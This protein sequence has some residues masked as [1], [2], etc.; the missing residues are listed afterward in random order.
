MNPNSILNRV[1]AGRCDIF[2]GAQLHLVARHRANDAS[3]PT[4]AARGGPWRGRI[5]PVLAALA[6][7][8]FSI[9]A[10][11]ADVVVSSKAD[12]EGN[13]LGNIIVEVLA[14]HGVP[15]QSR[16]QLGSTS[17]V[18]SAIATG[19]IDIYPEYTGDGAFLFNSTDDAIWKD[20]AQSY[21][22]VKRLD[23]DANKL[24][25]LGAAPA[26]NTWGI[27]LR[28]DVADANH[29]ATFSDFATWVGAG[30]NIKLAASAVF[31]NSPPARPAFEKAYGF[32]LRSD[33]LVSLTAGDTAE[34]IAAAAQQTSGV[35]AGVA[36]GTDGGII[37]SGL[38]FLIDDKKVQPVYSPVPV[39]REPVLK[40][41]PEI[42]SLLDPVFA[43]L[44]LPTL[45]T[46]NGRVEVGGEEAGAVAKDWLKSSGI[47][48]P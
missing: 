15:T 34:T 43:R 19:Q 33:Q 41:Y 25:W 45:Q 3:A 20:A 32:V 18:R 23:Y 6:V 21:A 28:K 31:I 8:S 14:A 9:G 40:Q 30:G 5:G 7:L 17:I 27:A 39:V 37:E 16:L 48:T 26:N 11:Q 22:T 47:L 10:A 38:V 4:R 29:I 2:G 24:V 35:N 46:L 1:A 12:T 44:D 13:V 42:A 36:F